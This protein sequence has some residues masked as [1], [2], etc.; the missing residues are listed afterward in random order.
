MTELVRNGVP[1]LSLPV[2]VRIF[3]SDLYKGPEVQA[4]VATK[5]LAKSKKGLRPR[6]KVLTQ[7][8]NFYIL[9]LRLL[10]LDYVNTLK[11]LQ[12]IIRNFSD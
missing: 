2:E 6:V 8:P 9:F 3:V 11:T 7:A 5:A 12:K 4:D 1:K 10:V